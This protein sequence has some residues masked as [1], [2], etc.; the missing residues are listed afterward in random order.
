MIDSESLTRGAVVFID[1]GS[2]GNPGPSASAFALSIAGQHV[3]TQAKFLGTATNNVA[4]YTAL[5]L[6]S[7]FLADQKFEDKPAIVGSGANI[8]VLSDSK[9][10]VNQMNAEW[11]TKD[12]NLRDIQFL[13]QRLLNS[14][15]AHLHYR[16]IPR[17]FNVEADAAVNRV[18]DSVAN[19]PYASTGEL[20]LDVPVSCLFPEWG[21]K[22]LFPVVHNLFN[23]KVY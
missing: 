17:R 2:R 12:F 14:S 20:T 4:E 13:I 23:T 8:L 15:G 22:N 9:L 10:L 16:Y 1:G 18:L 3:R 6:F 21:S 7:S 11:A 5:E 19:A